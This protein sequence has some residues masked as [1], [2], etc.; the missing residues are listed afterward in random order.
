MDFGSDLLAAANGS[1]GDLM[2]GGMMDLE[3]L[4]MESMGVDD[5]EDLESES[6]DMDPEDVKRK[7]FVQK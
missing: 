5:L 3:K 6:S 2:Q 7:I 4:E 1:A